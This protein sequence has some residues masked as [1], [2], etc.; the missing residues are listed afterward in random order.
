MAQRGQRKCLCCLALFIPDHRNAGRQR[1]CQA[2]ACR[3]ASKAASQAAWLAKPENADYFKDPAHVLRSQAWRA[4]HPG[5]ARGRPRKR[6]ALQDSLPLEVPDSV[7][8]TGDRVAPIKSPGALALQDLLNP[9]AA[10]WAGLI[11]HLFEVSLQDDMVATTRRLVQ[12]GQDLILGVAAGHEVRGQHQARAA[13]G[14][15]AASA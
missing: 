10:M 14:A 4:L 2:A 6:R 8:Q 5:Y 11:A 13:P 9:S 1:Y 3:R 7:E 15:A 12:Q